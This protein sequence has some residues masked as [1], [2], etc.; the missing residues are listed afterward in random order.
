MGWEYLKRARGQPA[1]TRHDVQPDVPR[2]P[3]ADFG[4]VPLC[5]DRVFRKKSCT[6]LTLV[7]AYGSSHA[8][9]ASVA[10]ARHNKKRIGMMQV[11]FVMEVV[12]FHHVMHFFVLWHSSRVLI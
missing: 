2:L 5:R 1:G 3:A 4:A 9:H 10:V 11:L 8:D 12:K 7:Q 6:W